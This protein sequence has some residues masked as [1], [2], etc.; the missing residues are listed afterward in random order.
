MP[1]AIVS[2]V[3]GSVVS[4]GVI[5]T[6][7]LCL[8][9]SSIR[10]T[11]STLDQ[12]LLEIAPFAGFVG[13][14]LLIKRIGHGPSV[15]L[16]RAIDW[17]ITPLLYRL[18]GGFVADLQTA[19]PDAVVPLFAA[20]YVFGFAYLVVAPV[21]LYFL[22][23]SRQ[24]LKELLVAYALNYLLGLVLYTLFVAR[25]PRLYLSDGVDGLLFQMYPQI[26]HLTGAVSV[27]TN[28]FPSLHTAL[29]VIVFLFAWRTRRT[30]PRW[31]VVAATVTGG[32]VLSTMVLG[33]HWLVDVVAGVALALVSVY[34]AT[35]LVAG[36]ESRR[37]NH[38]V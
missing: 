36:I 22:G 33:I 34:G 27:T 38:A 4:L 23:S 3:V 9:R 15:R 19:T 21:V 30:W 14:A 2:L 28:V 35:R 12:A 29:S 6:G 31:V 1:L 37:A 5:A 26:R 11:V 18:E 24:A 10:R 7:A 32:V 25:G 20:F 16:S 8:D 17:N 13:A